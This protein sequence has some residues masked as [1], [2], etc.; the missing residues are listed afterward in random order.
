MKAELEVHDF[1]EGDVALIY[2]DG[3]SDNVFTSGFHHCVEEYLYDGVVTSLSAAADCLAKK[4]YW[5]GLN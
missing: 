2:S 3:F 5:L 1:R 4:A